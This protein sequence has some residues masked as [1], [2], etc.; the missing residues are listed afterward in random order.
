VTLYVVPEADKKVPD[1]RGMLYVDAEAKLNEEG[2]VPKSVSE[3]NRDVA[4]GK[5]IK[6]DPEGGTPHAELT[7]LVYV[8]TD[9]TPEAVV[10]DLSGWDEKTA[11]EMLESVRLRL[12]PDVRKIDSDL[13]EGKVVWQSHDPKTKVP[14]NTRIQ[15]K[16][17]NGVRPAVTAS[18]SIPLPNRGGDGLLKIYLDSIL[19]KE[20]TVLLVGGS[21]TA[22][23]EGSGAAALLQAYVDDERIYSCTLDFISDPPV[24]S[25]AKIYFEDTP[26]PAVPDVRLKTQ[27]DAIAALSAAG[28][29]DVLVDSAGPPLAVLLSGVVARQSPAGGTKADTDTQI[30]I[31]VYD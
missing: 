4:P 9:T 12:D 6:T 19:V 3:Y 20:A 2:F 5:V 1:V 25:N 10:P 23:L 7:V 17:S 26:L 16:V 22:A 14:E 31:F 15:I 29:D 11:K 24:L 30:T 18:L 28:Y 21:Y 27:A 8:A 13:E